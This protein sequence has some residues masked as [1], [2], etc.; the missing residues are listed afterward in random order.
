MAELEKKHKTVGRV[1]GAAVLWAIDLVEDKKTMEPFRL[2]DRWSAYSG[3]LSKHP[4]NI[5]GAKAME[6][7]CLIN[8]F[9]P[10]TIRFGLS[11]FVTKED[12][13]KAID[14]FDYALTYLDTLA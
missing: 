11:V 5:I 4:T 6:K 8:G 3:D 12:M 2:E 1:S 7:G 10:N 9:T 14:A 13:D